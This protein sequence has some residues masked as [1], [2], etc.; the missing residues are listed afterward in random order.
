MCGKG[1]LLLYKKERRNKDVNKNEK[2]KKGSKQEAKPYKQTNFVCW[3][4]F[5]LGLFEEK[6][7]NKTPAH[8][9]LT[10]D[11][12]TENG[13]KYANNSFI[14]FTSKVN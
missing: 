7:T 8:N 1:K 13:E 11:Y 3:A 9:T 4:S 5:F 14:N 10:L 6:L 12:A 2:R